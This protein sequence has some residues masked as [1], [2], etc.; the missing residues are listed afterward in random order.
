MAISVTCECGKQFRVKEEY[1]G[2]RA[3]CPECGRPV[4]IPTTNTST[5]PVESGNNARPDFVERILEQS[6]QNRSQTDIP[7]WLAA[8]AIGV[9]I[10]TSGFAFYLGSRFG[11]GNSQRTEDVAEIIP[12]EYS[13]VNT[14]LQQ[15]REKRPKPMLDDPTY[16]GKNLSQWKKQ[17]LDLDASMR[18]EAA[19][20]VSIIE[21]SNDEANAV[22]KDYV[23]K[24][25]MPSI[26][27][28]LFEYRGA[29]GK[30]P[31][32]GSLLEF[33]K[34]PWGRSLKLYGGYSL[35]KGHDD[36]WI[37]LI[38]EGPT[39]EGS[40]NSDSYDIRGYFRNPQGERFNPESYMPRTE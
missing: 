18:L 19:Q 2:K 37:C 6:K 31:P 4:V 15:T 22:L 7:I 10:I 21:P 13:V 29:N 12:Q 1:A 39:T 40:E 35:V 5:V 11:I 32:L 26:A 33:E 14:P 9:I 17:L 36:S 24:V 38:S 20:A 25:L 27:I 30:Y 3:K 34:D 16:R 8:S 23:L 28:K